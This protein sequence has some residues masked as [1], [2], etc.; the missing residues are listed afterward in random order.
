[1]R[2]KIFRALRPAGCLEIGGRRTDAIPRRHQ[3]GANEIALRPRTEA[4]RDVDTLADQIDDTVRQPHVEREI[5]VAAPECS[6]R[7]HDAAQAEGRGGC[8]A[9]IA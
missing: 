8:N 1:M 9:E 7:R 6:D 2:L 3:A 5:G 4:N